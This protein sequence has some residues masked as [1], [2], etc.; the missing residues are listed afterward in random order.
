MIQNKKY[1]LALIAMSFFAAA[2]AHAGTGPIRYSCNY[3]YY[4]AAIAALEFEEFDA[5]HLSPK[6]KVAMT[7]APAHE[8]TLTAVPPTGEQRLHAW[9]SNES[10]ENR[11]ELIVYKSATANGDTEIINSRMPMGKEIWG[12]CKK[13]F[14]PDENGYSST[15]FTE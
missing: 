7:G 11:I 9:I 12:Q 2:T 8:E 13:T 14:A 10:P 1:I 4:G 15:R 5:L 3:T 6:V